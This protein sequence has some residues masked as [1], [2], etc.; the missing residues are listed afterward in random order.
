M[1]INEMEFEMT[2]GVKEASC[3]LSNSVWEENEY[4]TTIDTH[5][6]VLL[7]SDLHLDF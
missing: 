7:N 4:D 1:I 3:S 5:N 6:D 2:L